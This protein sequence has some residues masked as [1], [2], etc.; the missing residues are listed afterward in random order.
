MDFSLSPSSGYPMLSVWSCT[1][2]VPS[3]LVS[4]VEFSTGGFPERWRGFGLAYIARLA[5]EQGSNS[6]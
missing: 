1:P 3:I 6:T 5:N 4:L 2:Y